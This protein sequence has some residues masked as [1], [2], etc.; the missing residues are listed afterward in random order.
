MTTPI[1]QTLPP[2][3]ADVPADWIA[4]NLTEVQEM[5]GDTWETLE[6]TAAGTGSPVQLEF[7][8]TAPNEEDAG[9]L[10]DQLQLSGY[11]ARATPPDSELDA[12]TVKGTTVEATV[13]AAGLDEWVRRMVA[14][15]W[16]HGESTLDGWSAVLG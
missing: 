2:V 14:T 15:A 11:E 10:A 13:T 4:D 1:E 12:W 7:A 5:N 6:A 9:D 3:P 8:F 16:P